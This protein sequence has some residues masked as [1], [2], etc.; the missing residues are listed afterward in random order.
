MTSVYL[1]I[2]TEYSA[3]LAHGPCRVD[4]AENFAR[5]IAC[6]TPEGPAGITHKLDL[7]RRHNQRAVFFVDPMPA[8]VWGVAA[9]EDVVAPI[10]EAGQDVQLH[11]HTE[12]LDLAPAG[13]PLAGLSGRNIKDFGFEDQCRILDWARS[14]LVLAGAPGPVAF[15]AGNYGANRD[16]LRALREI[17]LDF[18]SSHTPGIA[19][20]ESDL[21]LRAT[22]TQ[23]LLHEGIVELPVS[24]VG[25]IG[26]RLRH[27]QVTALSLKEMRA[28]LLHARDGRMSSFTIVSHS[29]ELVNRRSLAVNRLVRARF[30]GLCK[31]IEATSGI[32]TGDFVECPPIRV[33]RRSEMPRPVPANTM[34]VGMRYAEQ[35]ISNTLYG[36]L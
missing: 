20:G 6:I 3:A 16:T 15:R 25:D 29:F 17:G 32:W 19:G 24:C 9:I 1:T 18:D 7:L 5:S 22:D 30:E 26:G 36:A 2:D 14:T 33:F 35:A 11:C 21:D 12:W 13:G 8:L 34:S 28:A 4:R 31:F 10:I 23:P 27:A